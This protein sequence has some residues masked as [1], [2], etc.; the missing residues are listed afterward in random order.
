MSDL[1]DSPGSIDAAA[2]FAGARQGDVICR[3]LVDRTADYIAQ[4]LVS[5]MML[6]LPDYIVFTGG[7]LRSFDFLE[8]RIHAPIANYNVIIPAKQ[9]QLQL[10]ELGQQAGMFGAA[11]AAQLLL[12]ETKK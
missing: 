9:V 1:S 11:R 12:M 8:E 3:Q 7:I 6:T 5:V 10:A 2:V 4:G